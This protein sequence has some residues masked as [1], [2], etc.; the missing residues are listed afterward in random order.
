LIFRRENFEKNVFAEFT[1]ETSRGV[2]NFYEKKSPTIGFL[3]VFEKDLGNFLLPLYK[4]MKSCKKLQAKYYCEKCDYTSKNKSNFEKHL[5]TT[6]HK[7]G[8]TMV[9]NG[10]KKLPAVLKFKCKF[11]KKVYK[12]R[13]GLCRHRK[14]CEDV[15]KN[16]MLKFTNQK[17]Q[18]DNASQYYNSDSENIQNALKLLAQTMAKQESILEKLVDSQKEMIPCIGNNNNN[19]ISI[20][21]FLNEKCKDAMNL[22]DFVNNIKIS[23]EDLQYTN[24]HGYVKGISNIFQKNLTDLKATE[25]P[26]HCSDTKRLQF[27]VKEEDKWEKDISHH[28][29]NEGINKVGK[30]QILQIKEWEKEHPDFLEHEV[31]RMEWNKMIA[32][33]MGGGTETVRERNIENIKKHISEKVTVKDALIED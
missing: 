14:K 17:L 7:N 29:I 12:F 26:I 28:K 8:N 18:D 6:K 11:C 9:T 21:I 24:Q 30:K 27:Y 2:L 16:E 15:H 32:S 4:V 31:Q 25:R 19:K 5:S 1:L 22:T 13:S 10:N 3:C 33:I 20:N 23:L